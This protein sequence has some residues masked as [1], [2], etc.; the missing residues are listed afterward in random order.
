MKTLLVI[1]VLLLVV[2]ALGFYRGWLGVSTDSAVH[3]PSATITLDR[4]KIQQDEEKVRQFAHKA[5][6]KTIDRTDKVT[7]QE[8]LP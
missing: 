4:D 3:N 2:I 6:E 1:A 5:T 7:G 8:R